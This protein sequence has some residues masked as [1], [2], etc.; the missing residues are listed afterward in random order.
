L[1]DGRVGPVDQDVA[2]VDRLAV[3]QQALVVLPHAADVGVAV[4]A[5]SVHN[6]L[7]AGQ[8]ALH[9]NVFR[10]TKTPSVDADASGFATHGGGGPRDGRIGVGGDQL[11]GRP[12]PGS[13]YRVDHPVLVAPGLRQRG[14][15]GA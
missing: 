15:V 12:Q 11:V 8:E 14:T 13:S 3:G 5:D 7:G 10:Q 1:R 4:H 6:V 2:V 9:Q